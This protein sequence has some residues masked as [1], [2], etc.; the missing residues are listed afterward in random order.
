MPGE[1]D[2]STMTT[3][4][5]LRHRIR[6]LRRAVREPLWPDFDAAV[7]AAKTGASRGGQQNGPRAPGVGAV[8]LP[9]KAGEASAAAPETSA[10]PSDTAPVRPATLVKLADS[11]PS[12]SILTPA[13]SV[14][15]PS[16]EAVASYSA[17]NGSRSKN[18]SKA[19]L[20]IE[21]EADYGRL[22]R[23]FRRARRGAVEV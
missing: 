3:P 5:L 16:V 20:S 14:T 13:P 11:E 17:S 4:S 1:T 9:V 15:P 8:G 2:H 21:P 12:P 19:L 10:N 18:D 6:P 7:R 22:L 23:L